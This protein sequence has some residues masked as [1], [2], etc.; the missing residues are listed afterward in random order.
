MIDNPVI[1]ERPKVM[2]TVQQV[3]DKLGLAVSTIWQKNR[4][5]KMPQGKKYPHT[6]GTFWIEYELDDWLNET[7]I[8]A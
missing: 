6:E 7:L 8:P 5:G 2:L 3:S 4:E 1:N